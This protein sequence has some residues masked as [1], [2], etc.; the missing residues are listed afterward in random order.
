VNTTA[1]VHSSASRN[2][3]TTFNCKLD[4]PP[5]ALSRE[6]PSHLDPLPPDEYLIGDTMSDPGPPPTAH[7][8][9]YGDNYSLTTDCKSCRGNILPRRSDSIYVENVAIPVRNAKCDRARPTCA[10][11]DLRG[12]PCAYVRVGKDEGGTQPIAGDAF[13]SISQSSDEMASLRP[14]WDSTPEEPGPTPASCSECKGNLY[15][16]VVPIFRH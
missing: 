6:I 10:S 4:E 13:I 12:L 2:W 3:N 9:K 5:A 7:S 8:G 15:S 1:D 16:P 11:C 14:W